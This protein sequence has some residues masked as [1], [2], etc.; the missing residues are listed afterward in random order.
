MFLSPVVTRTQNNLDEISRWTDDHL[1]TINVSKTNYM[2]FTRSKTN[3]AT[4]LQLSDDKL[5]QLSATKLLGVWITEDLS[6][7]KNTKEIC[8]KSFSRISMLTNSS[9]QE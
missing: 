5:D 7:E 4:R 8:I 3:F 9:M 2:L 6:W 1:M